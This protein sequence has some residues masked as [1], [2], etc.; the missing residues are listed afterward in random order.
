MLSGKLLYSKENAGKAVISR[1]D[2]WSRAHKKKNSEPVNAL[3]AEVIEKLEEVEHATPLPSTN[4]KEDA[5]TRV[6][7]KYGKVLEQLIHMNGLVEL[8]M[9]NQSSSDKSGSEANAHAPVPMV[10]I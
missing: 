8:L 10:T 4:I 3:A 7:E 1:V 2:A 5:L 9:K 6:L